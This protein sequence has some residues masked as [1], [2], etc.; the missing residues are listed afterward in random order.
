MGTLM[1]ELIKKFG[2]KVAKVV[3]AL[4]L[5]VAVNIGTEAAA[6]FLKRKYKIDIDKSAFQK[7]LNAVKRP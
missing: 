2:P 6:Q 7:A 1:A 4:I 3:F 5:D